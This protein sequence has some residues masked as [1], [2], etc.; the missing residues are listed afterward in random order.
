MSRIIHSGTNILADNWTYMVVANYLSGKVD[1]MD[2]MGWISASENS[3]EYH[4]VKAGT[5]Q[6]DCLNSVIEQI[7]FTNEIHMM[8]GWTHF[9]TE[10]QTEL[11]QLL[12]D[13]D[14]GLVKL[15]PKQAISESQKQPFLDSILTNDELVSRYRIGMERFR[16]GEKDFW[17]QI[18]NGSAEYLFY[19]H[20]L[21]LTYSPH[22]VKARFLEQTAWKQKSRH[23]FSKSGVRSWN[24]IINEKRMKIWSS[25]ME[26]QTIINLSLK[27]PSAALFCIAESDDSYSPIDI[28]LQVRGSADITQAR[29]LLHHLT[30]ALCNSGVSGMKTMGELQYY[31]K[32][33]KRLIKKASKELRISRK[34]GGYEKAEVSNWRL[35]NIHKKD[36][37]RY[38][39]IIPSV[40]DTSV[41]NS[42]NILENRLKFDNPQIFDSLVSWYQLDPDLNRFVKNIEMNVNEG[43]TYNITNSHGNIIND[44]VSVYGDYNAIS[45]D[46]WNKIDDALRRLITE[47]KSRAESADQMDEVV[48]VQESIELMQSKNFKSAIQK[49]KSFGGWTLNLAKEIGIEIIASILTKDV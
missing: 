31:T 42:R 36:K 44:S 16:K 1:P 35:R 29:D 20:E 39:T 8:G 37:Y 18:L 48:K 46:Q 10:D 49:V 23:Q 7:I 17:S 24:E 33:L 47:V 12:S 32:E 2:T 3:A 26:D 30:L 6:L 11:N 5:I 43:N 40:L 13:S 14:N 4:E 22:P 27:I 34:K 38:N 15:I 25:A 19:A 9:W 21:G 45:S 28:A 41:E